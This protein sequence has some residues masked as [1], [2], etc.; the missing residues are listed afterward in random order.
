MTF[1]SSLSATVRSNELRAGSMAKSMK[2]TTLNFMQK[3]KTDEEKFVCAGDIEERLRS[4][5]KDR[6]GFD[7]YKSDVQRRATQAHASGERAR[8]LL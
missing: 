4:V 5:L 2:Q 1:P 7:D 3:K 6:F 8:Y